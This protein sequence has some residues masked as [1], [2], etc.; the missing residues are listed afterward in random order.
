M[1]PNPPS[2]ILEHFRI[3]GS[4]KCQYHTKHNFQGK[5][6]KKP[7][8]HVCTNKECIEDSLL[9][10]DCLSATYSNNSKTHIHIAQGHPIDPI[11]RYLDGIYQQVAIHPEE[12]ENELKKN[13]D[14]KDLSKVKD[15]Y[16]VT[17]IMLSETQSKVLNCV[18]NELDIIFQELEKKNSKKQWYSGLKKYYLNELRSTNKN[19][20]RSEIYYKIKKLIIEEEEDNTFEAKYDFK[21][22]TNIIQKLEKNLI[23][24]I[25]NEI[26]RFHNEFSIEENTPKKAKGKRNF[27]MQVPKESPIDLENLKRITRSQSKKSDVGMKTFLYVYLIY[28]VEETILYREPPISRSRRSKKEQNSVILE[29][30][31]IF[32]KAIEEAK[33]I[34]ASNKF[35]KRTPASE[36][37]KIND[38]ELILLP[39][40]V[41]KFNLIN[42][43]N[44]RK[45]QQIY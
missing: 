25:K 13:S 10:E 36:S 41:I 11:D 28:L 31:L 37:C 19:K 16:I 21:K 30:N 24:I 3:Q 32:Q 42:L 7:I 43:I 17:K 35:L 9:C 22:T 26:N 18:S 6:Q 1:K 14:M 20:I 45:P 39:P 44:N 38:E 40:Q 15:I 23:K 27:S 4:L 33:V 8:T 12:L 34:K 2:D 29:E 5:L